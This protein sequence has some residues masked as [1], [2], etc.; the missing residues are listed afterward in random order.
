MIIKNEAGLKAIEADFECVEISQNGTASDI[1]YLKSY[2]LIYVL[3]MHADL[4]FSLHFINPPED[5]ELPQGTYAI[6]QE[7]KITFLLGDNTLYGEVLED[8]RLHVYDDT[9][10]MIF[11]VQ[12]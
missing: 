8:G 6:D 5:A 9:N 11:T 10:D 2:D 12:K 3:E 7:N 1:G 4:S